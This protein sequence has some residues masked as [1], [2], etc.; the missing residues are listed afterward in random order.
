[1][2]YEKAL[3]LITL[4]KKVAAEQKLTFG[5]KLTNT[6]AMANDKGNLP[7]EDVYVRAGLVSHRHESAP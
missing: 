5:I 1:M 2:K 4:F 7:G 3:E 6:L